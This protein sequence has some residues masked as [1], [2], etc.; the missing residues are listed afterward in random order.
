MLTARVCV[1]VLSKRVCVHVCVCVLSAHVC[2]CV[3]VCVCV[4]VLT[5]H[6]RVC[7]YVGVPANDRDGYLILTQSLSKLCF[8]KPPP[9]TP[10]TYCM[11]VRPCA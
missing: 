11:F 5:L 9:P 10:S 6:V 2:L 1:H 3:C 4:C 8:Y 7:V